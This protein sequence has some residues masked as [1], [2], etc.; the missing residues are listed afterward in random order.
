MP[1]LARIRE[2]FAEERPLRGRAHRRLHARDHRDGESS[3]VRF[4]ASGAEVTLCASNPLST[5]DDTAASLVRDYG[6]RVYAIAGEDAETYERHIAEVVATN[7]QIIM[8]DGADL[9]TALHTKFPEKLE[10]VIGGTEETTTG[11]VRLM[12]M[13]KDGALTLPGVQHQRRATP[14]TA[15]T[16]TTARAS[17]PWTASCAP[18]TAFS[19]GPHHGSVRLRLLRKRSLALRA[20]GMGTGRHRLRSRPPEGAWRPTRRATA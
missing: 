9:D 2:R 8:D 6:V 1:V 18:R 13:A 4:V 3:C 10:G 17:P 5:Q 12:A 15:S 7:P 16:T 14:S 19:C 20:K 11:V